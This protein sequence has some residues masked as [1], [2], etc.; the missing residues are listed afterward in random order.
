MTDLAALDVAL[1]RAANPG[2]YT[3]SGTNTWIVG[4]DPAYVVDPGPLLEQHLAAIV[5]ETDRRGGIGGIALTHGHADHAEAVGELR[6]RTF[7]PALAAAAPGADVVLGDGD[8]F[9]PLRAIATP[10]HALDHVAFIFGGVCFTGD[11]VLGEGSVFVSPDRGAMTGYLRALR[12]LRELHLSVICPGHGPVV[13][14]PA[15]K[16]EQYLRHRLERERR[17]LDALGRGLRT[18]G[19]LL[20]EVWSDVGAALRPAAAATL[21]AHLDRLAERGLLPAGVERSTVRVGPV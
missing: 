8:R 4:R 19:E 16:L 10:G 9:G 2:P 7:S 20:D 18:T 13:W 14:D 17:L 12:R 15:A 1:L 21:A 3:L 6:A 11:A 5:A